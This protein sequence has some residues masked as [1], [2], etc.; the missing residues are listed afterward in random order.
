M[1]EFRDDDKKCE[2]LYSDKDFFFEIQKEHILKLWEEEKQLIRKERKKQ[3]R[4]QKSVVCVIRRRP[5]CILFIYNSNKVKKYTK[6]KCVFLKSPLRKRSS[7]NILWNRTL[8]ELSTTRERTV[9]ISGLRDFFFGQ[10]HFF[11]E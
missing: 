2:N 3:K 5:V 8:W 11:K 1:N 4:T 10:T 6:L 7:Q 9:V